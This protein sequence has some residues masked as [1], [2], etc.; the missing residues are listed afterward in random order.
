MDSWVYE[1][2]PRMGWQAWGMAWSLGAWFCPPG[3][4]CP[5][6]HCTQHAC[7]PGR[8][9][10]IGFTAHTPLFPPKRLLMFSLHGV[11]PVQTLSGMKPTSK[12]LCFY[13]LY[14]SN[15]K[16]G[17]SPHQPIL[18]LLTPAG[19]PAIQLHSDT[20]CLKLVQTPQVQGSAPQDC[21]HFGWGH[22]KS[23]LPA[24]LTNWL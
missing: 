11:P 8:G 2:E 3:G 23:G 4:N 15:T 1:I 18:Q 21:P 17:F 6:T 13:L 22:C 20:F 12:P 19:C 14:T 7:N 24:V 10:S 5:P 16:C 9:K